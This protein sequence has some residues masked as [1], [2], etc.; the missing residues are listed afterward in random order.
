[1]EFSEWGTPIV[2]TIKPDGSLRIYADYKITVNKCV[3]DEPYPI[4]KIDD[5]Y[6]NMNGEKYFCTLDLN[7]AYLHVVMDDESADMQT[8]STHKGLYKVNRLMFGV[9]P[10][11]QIWNRFMDKILQGIPGVFFFFD[12]IIVTGK[13]YEETLKRLEIVFKQLQLHNLKL[14]MPNANFSK[15][16]LNTSFEHYR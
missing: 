6:A 11:P 15:E 2:P 1:M 7:N 10:A 9:K 12:D 14:K 8:M 13:T 16:V 5:I 3:K 4:P